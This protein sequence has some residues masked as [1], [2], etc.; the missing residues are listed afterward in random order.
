MFEVI[1]ITTGEVLKEFTSKESAEEWAIRWTK[2]LA[3]S[4]AGLSCYG[5]ARVIGWDATHPNTLLVE[6]DE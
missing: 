4:E 6:D 5:K 1:N 3:F 2:G